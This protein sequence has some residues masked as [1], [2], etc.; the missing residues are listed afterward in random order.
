MQQNCD[1]YGWE[2]NTG[3]L[4]DENLIVM[5]APYFYTKL[6]SALGGNLTIDY[7]KPLLRSVCVRVS[8]KLTAT[9]C[10]ALQH[11]GNRCCARSVSA[12]D[13]CVCLRVRACVCVCV[14]VCACVCVCVRVC[15]VCVCLCVC[16]NPLLRSV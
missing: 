9:H 8:L 11:T 7:W 4:A 12:G 14:R 1:D 3:L 16:W 13:A 2:C 10:N 15:V 5:G 6:N